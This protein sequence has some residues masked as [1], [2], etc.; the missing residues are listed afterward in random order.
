MVPILQRAD[1]VTRSD[2]MLSSPFSFHLPHRWRV[3]P[4]APVQSIPAT[5]KSHGY[6]TTWPTA[7]I[8]FP[9][10]LAFFFHHCNAAGTRQRR[11]DYNANHYG[12]CQ[13]VSERRAGDAASEKKFDAHHSFLPFCSRLS[14]PP[15]NV[16]KS[17]G[18]ISNGG[19]R[20]NNRLGY[21]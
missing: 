5:G 15:R 19:S 21:T 10:F 12:T 13:W 16:S 3:L 6:G 2:M 8:T 1:D 14:A 7:T 11:S 20:R 17:N 9:P 18:Q 4:A